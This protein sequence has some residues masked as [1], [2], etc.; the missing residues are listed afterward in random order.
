[1]ND[2]ETEIDTL[3][4]TEDPDGPR[5]PVANAG[6][7]TS[8]LPGADAVPRDAVGVDPV[9]PDAP[10]F[11]ADSGADVTPPAPPAPP[12][13][14]VEPVVKPKGRGK[15]K[16]GKHDPAPIVH[17]DELDEPSDV[18][19][20]DPPPRDPTLGDMTPAFVDWAIEYYPRAA[21]KDYDER[22][23]RLSE[24]QRQALKLALKE[25]DGE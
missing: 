5:A 11:P 24:S 21:A 4:L 23:D 19:P 16:G 3:L 6:D 18:I 10:A 22:L 17:L 2:P 12:A 7:D 20:P 13:P 8:A 25:V 1:M 15:A 14:P 9:A